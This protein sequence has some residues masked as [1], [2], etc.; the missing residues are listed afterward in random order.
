MS[1]VGGFTPKMREADVDARLLDRVVVGLAHLRREAAD[2]ID[3]GALFQPLA[4]H[5]RLRGQRRAGHDIRVAHR[6]FEVVGDL[7]LE[8]RRSPMQRRPARRARAC[9]ST[10]SRAGSAAPESTG[11]ARASS[12]SVTV[13]GPVDLDDLVDRAVNGDAV[14]V[15][16]VLGRIHPVVV[17]YCRSRMSAGHRS[18]SSADDVAQEVCMAVFTALPTFRREEAVLAFV[19]GI[20]RTRSPTLIESRGD[21]GRCRW[22]RSPTHRPPSVG[23]S[24]ASS[25]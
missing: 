4:L 11:P 21:P 3:M 24:R 1:M 13:D 10:R 22:P 23:P 18:L 5:Q 17:R 25:R 9:G 8:T 19:Y 14:A 16:R 15:E 20:S 6:G 12:D 2:Q 7:D